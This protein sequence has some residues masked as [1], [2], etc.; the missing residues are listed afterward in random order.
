MSDDLPGTTPISSDSA[1]PTMAT[2]PARSLVICPVFLANPTLR[3]PEGAPLRNQPLA[4]ARI[5]PYEPRTASRERP[6]PPAAVVRCVPVRSPPSRRAP[7]LAAPGL[8]VS[9]R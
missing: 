3:R 8:P 7:A 5:A 1:T 9:H 6:V 2:L 4:T